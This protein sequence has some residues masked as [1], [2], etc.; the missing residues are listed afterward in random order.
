MWAAA[1]ASPVVS[2][3]QIYI[4]II[5]VSL[6]YCFFWTSSCSLLMRIIGT[7]K[8]IIGRMKRIIGTTFKNKRIE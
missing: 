6:Y 3:V 5:I 2:R 4:L 1:V 7:I 8:R